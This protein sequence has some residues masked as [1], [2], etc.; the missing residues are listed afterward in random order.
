MGLSSEQ[1]CEILRDFD[2]PD[3]GSENP[4]LTSEQVADGFV[5]EMLF[6]DLRKPDCLDEEFRAAVG[7]L[8]I[9]IATK[10]QHA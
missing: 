1:V 3:V 8:G 9:A 10:P 6:R 7:L 4:E 2:Q 5:E